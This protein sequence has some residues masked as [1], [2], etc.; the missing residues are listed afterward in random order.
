MV[1]ESRMVAKQLKSFDRIERIIISVK[2][3]CLSMMLTGNL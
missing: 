2:H 1:T 3:G